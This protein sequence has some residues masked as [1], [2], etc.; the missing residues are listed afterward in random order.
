MASVPPRPRPRPVPRAKPTPGASSLTTNGPTSVVPIVVDDDDM[1]IRNKGRNVDMWNKLNK[2]NKAKPKNPRSETEGDSV[3]PPPKKQKK[4]KTV[5]LGDAQDKINRLMSETLSDSDS[6]VL[7]ITE[8]SGGTPINKRKGKKRRSRSRSITPPPALPQ[9]QLQAARDLVRKALKDPP[10]APSPTHFDEADESTDTIIFDPELQKIARSVAAQEHRAY[11]EPAESDPNDTLEITIKWQPH[12]LNESGKTYQTVF[13]LNRTDSFRELF[14]AVA[15]DESILVES[16][17]MS[18]KRVPIVP[19]VTPAALNLWNDAELVA[20]E[21]TTWEYLRSNPASSALDT[22]PDVLDTD[23]PSPV[24]SNAEESEAESDA[25]GETFKLC[26]RSAV[27][28]K[29]ITVTVRPT[30]T[31]GAIVQA[32]LKKAGLA[33]KYGKSGRKSIGGASKKGKEKKAESDEDPQ[34]MIDG[35]KMAHATPIGDAEL[36][37]GDVVDVVGL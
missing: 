35:D 1:F 2:L 3:L 7:E 14:E 32:F 5:T 9:H 13:K 8:A 29:D 37:D 17:V 19:S 23:A 22:E 26:L 30:T 11:S 15:E 25:G 27:T 33:D 6:D 34:L 31:C 28:A 24:H 36:D 4:K 21:K 18:Y 10:R 20:C 16:L 12:P